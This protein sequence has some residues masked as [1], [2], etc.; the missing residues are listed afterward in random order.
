MQTLPGI[1]SHRQDV[2][3]VTGHCYVTETVDKT[4]PDWKVG[5]IK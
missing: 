2:H 3:I 4:I 1:Y 5:A